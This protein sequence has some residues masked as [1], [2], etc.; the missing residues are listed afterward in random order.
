MASTAG[1]HARGC[2]C[3]DCG[4]TIPPTG[5]R[6]PIGIGCSTCLAAALAEVQVHSSDVPR[7]RAVVDQ[8]TEGAVHWAQALHPVPQPLNQPDAVKPRV[9]THTGCTADGRNVY[10]FRVDPSSFSG[11][12]RG[13]RSTPLPAA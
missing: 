7:A 3:L 13:K 6:W 9:W 8:R 2:I 12:G 4:S 10:T 1:V 5:S 11:D